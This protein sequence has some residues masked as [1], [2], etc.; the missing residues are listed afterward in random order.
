MFR[1]LAGV[2]ALACVLAMAACSDHK[3]EVAK[4]EKSLADKRDWMTI[5]VKASAYTA[6]PQET[7]AVNPDIAAWGDKLVPG[8][9]CIAVSRDLIPMGLTH[10]TP[11]KIDGLPGEYLVKDKMNKRWTKKIDIFF[12]N[13]VQ[14]ARQWGVKTVTIHWPKPKDKGDG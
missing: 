10:N 12:G 3:E 7:K 6:R 9:K 2:I 4:A 5:E 11:V 13:D 8:M 1:S 14:S